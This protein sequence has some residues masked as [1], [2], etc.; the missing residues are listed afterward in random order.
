MLN[1][2]IFMHL[3]KNDSKPFSAANG[4]NTC[5]Y[6]IYLC[7]FISSLYIFHEYRAGLIN[8]NMN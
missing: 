5:S 6:S 2:F 3:S 1:S 4:R 8:I 7:H